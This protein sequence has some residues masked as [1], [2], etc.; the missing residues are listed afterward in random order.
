MKVSVMQNDTTIR[1]N[2]S[3]HISIKSKMYLNLF[4]TIIH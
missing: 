3:I 4:S 1:L 2:F